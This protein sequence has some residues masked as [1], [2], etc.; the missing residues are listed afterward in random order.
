[1]D[2]QSL[3]NNSEVILE[4]F[5]DPE[6]SFCAEIV[7]QVIDLI[8]QHP[9]LA[10]LYYYHYPLSQHQLA[11][12]ASQSIECAG[13]QKQFWPYLD[14]IY[15][16]QAALTEDDFYK[17]SDSLNLNTEEMRQCVDDGIFREKVA[18]QI[19]EAQNRKI[20]GTPTV[21]LNGDLIEWVNITELEALLTPSS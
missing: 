7:P 17:M 16:N 2:P 1:M 10:T 15:N 19:R 9:D 12:L 14:L 21:F 11:F 4:I 6:C 3:G 13:E 5:S 18:E 8:E 20:S